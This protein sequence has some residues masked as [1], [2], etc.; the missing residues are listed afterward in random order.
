[1]QPIYICRKQWDETVNRR[2]ERGAG[3]RGGSGSA[4]RSFVHKW[5]VASVSGESLEVLKENLCT[6]VGR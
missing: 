1:M 3:D 5:N 2:R 4:Y 6:L